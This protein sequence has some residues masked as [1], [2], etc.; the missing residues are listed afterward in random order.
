MFY[1]RNETLTSQH[2]F[3]SFF[4]YI[5]AIAGKMTNESLPLI[6]GCISSKKLFLLPQVVCECCEEAD[7]S[8]A[9]DKLM[10]RVEEEQ[11]SEGMLFRLLR[12]VQKVAASSFPPSLVPLLEELER[13]SQESDSSQAGGKKERSGF[14]SVH[15]SGSPIHRR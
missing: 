15:Y 12:T 1:L 6:S 4:S 7:P 10:R 14:S 9:L 13:N 3:V 2:A 11:L 8:S 5:F